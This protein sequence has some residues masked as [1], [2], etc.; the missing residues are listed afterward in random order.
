[1]K[2]GRPSSFSTLRLIVDAGLDGADQLGIEHHA[3]IRAGLRRIP[4]Q[5]R[6]AETVAVV[7]TS[8]FINRTFL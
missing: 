7:N 3:L 1:M 8:S 4:Q 6:A 2:V 5:S